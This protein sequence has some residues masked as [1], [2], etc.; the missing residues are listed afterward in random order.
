MYSAKK[1][2]KYQVYFFLYLAV[3]CELLIIIVE[4]D[5]A[6]AGWLKEKA[7]L[8]KTNYAVILE[9]L[10]NN[11]VVNAGSN[12]QLKV[13]EVREF[14][15]A[16][17]GLGDSD[18]VT[19]PPTVSVSNG[20]RQDV[21]P[22]EPLPDVELGKK[23]Y[24]FTWRAPAAGNY[25]FKVNAGT[26]RVDEIVGVDPKVKIGSLFFKKKFVQEV[27]D[28][29][30]MIKGTP[31][32]RFVDQSGHLN[33]AQFEIQVISDFLEQLT[34][35][36]KDVVTAIGFKTKNDIFIEGTTP[37]RVNAIRPSVGDAFKG[38][39]KWTWEGT[40]NT[41]GNFVVSLA[42]S[43][44]RGHAKMSKTNGSFRVTVKSPTL[45]NRISTAFA[46][47]LFE[48]NISVAGLEDNTAYSWTLEVDGNEIKGS[49]PFVR[50]QIPVTSIGKSLTIQG[51][52]QGQVYPID[53]VGTS[54]L[55]FTVA[56]PNDHIFE[57]SASNGVEYP[58][59]NVFEFSAA[60]CG[61]C[62]IE[63]REPIK[64][65]SVSV[66][67]ANGKDLLDEVQTSPITSNN[68]KTI[69]TKV[70]FYLKGKVPK[71][72]TEAII[73]IKAGSA[74]RDIRIILLP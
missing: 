2:Q 52:Y 1:F 10:K 45:R 67:D 36:S 65:I 23:Q 8:K 41:D 32:D 34:L 53:S 51:R 60:R 64:D 5:D 39:K 48:Q 30:P 74:R 61:R 37:D 26:N 22:A 59:N 50:Y 43:D 7:E 16:I 21:L 15:V 25:L 20:S 19:V 29:D 12:T 18:R 27:I 24:R 40:F 6:E 13:G 63:N 17:Q 66:E 57:L 38:E 73:K 72:G 44:S 70:R 62:L 47:E 69:G 71:S 35:K 9:L 42:A 55:H 58:I 33:P 49:G 68:G 46:G 54:Q 28:S 4:R 11:P 14:V 3:V 56:S 31:V